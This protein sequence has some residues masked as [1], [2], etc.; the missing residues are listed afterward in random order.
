MTTDMLELNAQSG[1]ITLSLE[2]RVLTNLPP[3]VRDR[4][5]DYLYHWSD[6]QEQLRVI[7]VLRAAHGPLLFL[8]DYQ[9]EAY[10]RSGQ[11]ALA[12]DVI[13]RRQRRSTTIASQV[14]E[15]RT[16]LATG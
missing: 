8:L 9:A 15:A 11:F 2:T 1:S 6:A 4:L 13:E 16:L 5:L 7:E 3:D 12:L 10:Y 14:L